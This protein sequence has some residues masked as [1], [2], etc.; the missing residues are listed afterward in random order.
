MSVLSLSVEDL[1]VDRFLLADFL[2][3][4]EASAGAVLGLLTGGRSSL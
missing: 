2:L 1:S 4:G 3:T